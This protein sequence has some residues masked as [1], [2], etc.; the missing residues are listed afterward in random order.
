MG[1]RAAVRN[2]P[3]ERIDPILGI[4]DTHPRVRALLLEHLRSLTAED[5]LALVGGACASARELQ[6]AGMR[7]LFPDAS[8]EELEFKVHAKRIGVEHM[9]RL[10]G[11]D[12]PW[13]RGVVSGPWFDEAR[14]SGA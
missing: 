10:V 5:K 1:A 3:M 4:D 14:R 7:H 13:L 8:D 6:L 11:A 9:A 2:R 12:H